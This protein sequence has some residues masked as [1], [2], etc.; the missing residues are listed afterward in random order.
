MEA[1]KE[2]LLARI[3]ADGDLC[4]FP[5]LLRYLS[6][7]GIPHEGGMG[8]LCG[9]VDGVEVMYWAGMPEEVTGLLGS[10]INDKELF[11]YPVER[12]IYEARDDWIEHPGWNPVMISTAPVLTLAELVQ[13]QVA[14]IK[15]L[16]RNES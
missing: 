5:D 6:E 15:N 4:T 10:M 8:S 13:K 11:I 14:Y 7:S 9:L 12:E 1:I 3:R 16:W 2:N